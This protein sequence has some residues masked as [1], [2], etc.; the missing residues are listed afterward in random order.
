MRRKRNKTRTHPS[1][2]QDAPKK[3]K[4]TSSLP[5]NAD[6]EN[7]YTPVRMPTYAVVGEQR[8][9]RINTFV[10]NVQDSPAAYNDSLVARG[11]GGHIVDFIDNNC[12]HSNLKL[13]SIVADFKD[14]RIVAIV[15]AI[16]LFNTIVTQ[17]L[18][19]S[20][21]P[22]GA[23][24]SYAKAKMAD[25][26]KKRK[27]KLLKNAQAKATILD[28]LLVHGD[29]HLIEMVIPNCGMNGYKSKYSIT[30]DEIKLYKTSLLNTA[31]FR[32]KKGKG[33]GKK[34]K[35]S[36]DKVPEPVQEP[37]LQPQQAIDSESDMDSDDDPDWV[38]SRTEKVNRNLFDRFSVD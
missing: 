4:T 30:K 31:G 19:N 32:I 38:P 8:G 14:E 21:L 20:S 10:P 7:V 33:R 13:K 11:S 29:S 22:Y 1:P 28:N 15:G 24:P 17:Q 5:L 34:S 18:M 3:C 37:D 23:F 36:T 35:N 16:A 25:N 9:P 12:T 26:D 27:E 6:M 2:D